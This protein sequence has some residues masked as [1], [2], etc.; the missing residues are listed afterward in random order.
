MLTEGNSI[1]LRKEADRVLAFICDFL[2]I[3]SKAELA[4]SRIIVRMLQNG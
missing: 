1:F 4:V 3:L 2:E